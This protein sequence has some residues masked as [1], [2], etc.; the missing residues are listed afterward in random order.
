MLECQSKLFSLPD[1]LHY[2]N[3]AYMSPLPRSVEEAG[4]AGMRRKRVPTAITA[5]DFFAD[6]DRVRALFARLV[7][8]PDPGRVAIVPAAS[9][10]LAAVARNTRL[11]R[12]QNIVIADE[13]F[14]SN[15]YVWSRLCHDGGAELR[16]VA[17]PESCLGAGAAWSERV[18]DAMDGDTAVV[19]LP[20]LHW[21]DGTRFDLEQIGARARELGAAFV[22][23]GTQSVGALPFDVQEIQPDAL[24]CSGYKWLLGPYAI[25][26]AYY[27][28]RYDDGEPLEETWIAREGSEDFQSL[29]LYRDAYQPGAVRYDAGGSPNF[30]LVPMLAAALEQVLEWTPAAIQEYC[31]ALTREL[32]EA[33]TALGYAVEAEPWRAAHLFGLRMPPGIDL[34]RAHA[35]LG[36]RRV[37]VSLRGSAMRVSP[38]VYNRVDDIAALLG[39]LR[40]ITVR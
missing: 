24:V 29:V 34:G 30:I 3:C 26:V 39:A 37:I 25:G 7:N 18:L 27:G 8:A 15:V 21:T 4:M 33:A 20:E 5:P 35:L 36:E 12:G 40:A 19:A 13:Q 38:H 6:R 14:P 9:Y 32:I 23:D 28:P 2:L 31:S 10:G 16:R 1:D 17:R 22:I 11:V